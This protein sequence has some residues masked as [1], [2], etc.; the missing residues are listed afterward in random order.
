MKELCIKKSIWAGSYFL[1]ALAFEFITFEFLGFGAFPTY[2]WLDIAV[3]LVLSVF[4][5]IIPSFIAQTVLV[6][7]LLTVQ[8]II[9]VT[10]E[11]LY[12]MSGYIFGLSMLSLAGEAAGA[13]D[14]D[15]VNFVFL[16]CGL[17]FVAAEGVLLIGLL[18]TG[19]FRCSARWQGTLL[20]IAAFALSCVFA[21]ALMAVQKA[22]FSSA[23]EDDPL[24]YFKDEQNLYQTQFISANAYREYGTF[25][26]YYKNIR[27]FFSDLESAAEGK[28]ETQAEADAAALREYFLSGKNSAELADLD[29]TRYGSAGSIAT[30]VLD[31]QNVALIVIES[32]EWYAINSVYTP[33]LYALADQGVAF[34]QYYAR[35]KTNYSEAMAVLGSYPMETRNCLTPSMFSKDGLMDHDFAFTLPN[36][37]QD[38]GYTT[39]YFHANSGSFYGRDAT[40]GDLYGFDRATFLESMDRLRGYYHKDGF[41]SFDLDS[42]FFSQYLREFTQTDEGDEAY[43]SMLMSITSHGSYNELLKHGDYTADMTA[44]EKA[45]FSEQAL[46]KGLEPYYERI[47]RFPAAEENIAG[48]V[49]VSAPMRGE[50]G[51]LTVGYL[52]YKRYQASLMDL[53]VGVNRL[54]ADLEARGELDNTTFIFYA[55]HNGYYSGMQYELKEVEPDTVWDTMLYNIPFFF[56]S[57]KYMDLTVQSDLYEGMVYENNEAGVQSV[58]TGEYYYDI[59]HRRTDGS[60]PLGG[61]KITKYCNSFDLLPT[62]LD[63]LGYSYDTALYQGVSAFEQETS[64][65][66][67]R[68]SGMF[69]DTMYTDGLRVWVRAAS[70]GSALVSADGQIVLADGTVSVV[71]GGASRSYTAEE[72]GGAY[73]SDGAFIVIDLTALFAMGEGEADGRQYLSDGVYDFLVQVNGYYAKQERLE[74]MYALDYFRYADI[75]E[76][77]G[78]I[79]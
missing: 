46:V 9:A 73:S 69:N 4:I 32:G 60:F 29:L 41:Y 54:L 62:M 68:E 61:A 70:Q 21:P 71:R 8:V 67:S 42:E 34:T 76:L 75:D 30:G 45:A 37:L 17:L 66:V 49:P 56:W 36:I 40:Y 27:N 6:L 22:A 13:F 44:E 12:T 39:Q 3:L 14:A 1:L 20:L 64:V 48:T 57:G 78:K 28:S 79:A 19:K 25:G 26:Y 58:Y 15:F 47:D 2:F 23:S 59:A 33:T 16:A 11:C 65:F 31:G 51:E 18:C 77:V 72:T 74:E 24:Y 38:N 5:F 63:L 55:D 50:D 10:N 35:D 52:R 43:F 53:D 7:L